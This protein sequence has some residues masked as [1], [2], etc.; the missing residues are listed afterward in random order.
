MS[1]DFFPALLQKYAKLVLFTSVTFSWFCPC[2]SFNCSFL[3]LFFCLLHPE[4]SSVDPDMKVKHDKLLSRCVWGCVCVSC[5]SQSGHISADDCVWW[6]SSIC[7]WIQ[8]EANRLL[9]CEVFSSR[10]VK[11]AALRCSHMCA[12]WWCEV[13]WIHKV[14]FGSELSH[15][16]IVSNFTDELSLLFVQRAAEV[17]WGVWVKSKSSSLSAVQWCV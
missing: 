10:E 8:V 7:L 9:H 6:I 14:M 1:E 3:F 15:S 2:L 12:C 11:A 5:E 16:L 4:S 13:S 17:C